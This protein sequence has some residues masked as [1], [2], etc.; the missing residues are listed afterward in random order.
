MSL[1]ALD[2]VEIAKALGWG[3]VCV[4]VPVVWGVAVN[5]V[6]DRLAKRPGG[7]RDTAPPEYHI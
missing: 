5:L 7:S 1:A 2:A 3:L 4:A 6:F